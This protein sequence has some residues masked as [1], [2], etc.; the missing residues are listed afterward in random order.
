MK[1]SIC[2]VP[3]SAARRAGVCFAFDQEWR[4]GSLGA[5]SAWLVSFFFWLCRALV[6]GVLPVR[7]REEFGRVL[8]AFEVFV[9]FAVPVFVKFGGEY[10]GVVVEW[11]SRPRR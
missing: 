10:S 1:H 6:R 7:D 4:E 11:L 5:K 2:F 3:L 9:P 8:F